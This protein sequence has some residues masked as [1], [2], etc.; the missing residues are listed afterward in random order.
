VVEVAPQS[1]GDKPVPPLHPFLVNAAG[2]KESQ[3][4]TLV[5]SGSGGSW[6]VDTKAR[7]RA[8]FDGRLAQATLLLLPHS[9][10]V[11]VDAELA[12]QTKESDARKAQAQK[13]V[14]E[15]NLREKLAVRR[16]SFKLKEI[17]IATLGVPDDAPI[18]D[19]LQLTIIHR[20]DGRVV[21]LRNPEDE[22]SFDDREVIKLRD[23]EVK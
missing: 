10:E 18:R 8:C 3:L 12:L 17:L 6:D 15:K 14:L 5:R 23:F 9:L 2:D 20:H 11:L 19:D 4:I 13:E 22:D 16:R 1:E 7:Q 21:E